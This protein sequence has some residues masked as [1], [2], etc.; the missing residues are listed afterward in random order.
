[1]LGGIL[2]NGGCDMDGKGWMDCIL[3]FE[4]VTSISKSHSISARISIKTILAWI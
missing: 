4:F 3:A 1:M 2:G